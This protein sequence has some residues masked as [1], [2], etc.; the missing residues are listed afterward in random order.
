MEACKFSYHPRNLKE[1]SSDKTM[2]TVFWNSIEVTHIN[3][4]PNSAISYYHFY[5]YNIYKNQSQEEVKC[6]VKMRVIR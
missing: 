4:Q 2:E 5:Y 6:V 1:I 3:I